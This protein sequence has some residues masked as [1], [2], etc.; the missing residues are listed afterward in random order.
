[1]CQDFTSGLARKKPIEFR[2]EEKEIKEKLRLAIGRL[3]DD[4]HNEEV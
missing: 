2:K 1:M 3:H 4:T